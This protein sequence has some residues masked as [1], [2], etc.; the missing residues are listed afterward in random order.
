MHLNLYMRPL[1]VRLVVAY[2]ATAYHQIQPGARPF[3]NCDPGNTLKRVFGSHPYNQM[4]SKIE[5]F[6]SNQGFGEL[7]DAEINDIAAA[8]LSVG[9]TTK[10]GT[11]LPAADIHKAVKLWHKRNWFRYE[12]RRDGRRK[13]A[14]KYGPWVIL[15]VASGGATIF[16][17]PN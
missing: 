4:W 12:N 2:M 14:Y 5:T 16:Q 9:Y 3:K 15:A 6:Y 13:I 8:A 11:K 1:R 10:N 17:P 7:S